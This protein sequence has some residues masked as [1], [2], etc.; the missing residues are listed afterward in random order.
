MESA[1]QATSLIGSPR[2]NPVPAAIAAAAPM[3]RRVLLWG[4]ASTV[5][6]LCREVPRDAVVGKK[7]SAMALRV[8]SSDCAS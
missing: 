1:S 6:R 2:I 3:S 5:E 8:L 7:D 4:S